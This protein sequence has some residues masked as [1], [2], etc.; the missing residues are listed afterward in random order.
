MKNLIKRFATTLILFVLF[1]IQILA[2]GNIAVNFSGMTPHVNQTLYLRVVDK[3][4]MK[5]VGRI[6]QIIT[7]ASFEVILPVSEPGRSYFIDF[8]ADLN[9]NGLYDAPP[10][11]HSWRIEL[12]NSG[13][14]ADTIS[15]NHNATFTDI[16]WPYE[17]TVNLSGMTPHIG[18][19]LEL[20]VEDNLTNKEID[21]IKIPS[22]P[23]ATFQ[24]KIPGIILNR[25]YKV[26]FF[27]DLNSNGIYDAP[28]ADHA[29]EIGFNNTSGNFTLDFS[30][31]TTFTD[32]NWKYLLTV[33]LNSMSPH[34]GQLFELRVVKQDNQEEIGRYSI[35]QIL[36]NDFT[37]FIPEF[38]LNH[39]YNIDFY[40]DF[41]GNGIY[42]A[43]PTD[44]AWRIT[45]ISSNGDVVQ[46]FSHNANFT[47]I[48]WPGATSVGDEI[49]SVE[50]FHL[51]Q[52]FPNPFNPSTKIKWS[53]AE[54][55]FQSLKVYNAIGNEVAVLVNEV[56]P[57]GNY[58][59]VFDAS[60]LSSGIYF[61]TLQVGTITET[62]KMILIK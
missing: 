5:E 26:E 57:A 8:F 53:T 24:V 52:N 58:E 44:H 61:Y 20:R 12:N 27:A 47:D 46:N 37:V 56:K 11:D 10:A 60:L 25:E 59:L 17:L 42:N 3:G 29:W 22:I 34:L 43:P 18:Q 32:I 13:G 33:N 7:S 30:H 2:H 45:F 48:Q 36:V 50:N 4:T 35:P 15:F 19:L 49:L 51:E 31:N 38:E 21:R 14:V 1:S 28:P 23:S 40:A 39:N 16:Q 9:S 55:G 41:N 62:K 6:S 54:N